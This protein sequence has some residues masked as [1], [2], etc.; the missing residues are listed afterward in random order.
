MTSLAPINW[1]RC[2]ECGWTWDDDNPDHA[3][4]DCFDR[5]GGRLVEIVGWHPVFD[6]NG[7]QTGTTTTAPTHPYF[8]V[9]SW[10]HRDPA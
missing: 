5:F 2:F 7:R 4:C 10:A 9:T 6:L 8:F 1:L 3:V